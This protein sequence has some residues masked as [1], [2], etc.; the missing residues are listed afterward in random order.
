MFPGSRA[1]TLIGRF[2]LLDPL[3]LVAVC[4]STLGFGTLATLTKLAYASGIEPP[5]LVL[6][7]F[8]L[9]V[10]LTSLAVPIERWRGRPL[11]GVQ[12]WP[13]RRRA[14]AALAVVSFAGNTTLY[15][16]ALRSLSVSTAAVLFYCYPLCVVLLEFL[17]WRVQPWCRR[18]LA[19]SLGIT[20]VV[21]VLGWRGT[22]FDVRAAG[23]MLLSASLYGAYITLA[24]R[25]FRD[26]SPVVTTALAFGT[27]SLLAAGLVSLTGASLG[28]PPGG[29]LLIAGIVVLATM[30][31]VQLFLIGTVRLGPAPAAILGTFE[32][33]ASVLIA[34]VTLGES[35]SSRQVMGGALVV[36]A[37]LLLRRDEERSEG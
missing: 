13:W 28:L 1:L 35:L 3:G 16:I 7:R 32:P 29:W 31:P 15:L 20:G 24:H 37:A 23:L 11:F 36:G 26:T 22:T 33:V 12:P 9:A 5:T 30:L 8:G 10:L 4:L 25:A 19:L 14:L 21:I 17:G 27:T 34:V 6:W 18:L 2:G